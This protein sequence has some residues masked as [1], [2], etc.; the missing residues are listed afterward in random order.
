MTSTLAAALFGGLARS[1]LI[2]VDL[3]LGTISLDLPLNLKG[4]LCLLENPGSTQPKGQGGSEAG[5]STS[6]G[7]GAPQSAG[8]AVNVC[9]MKECTDGAAAI[10]VSLN[11]LVNNNLEDPDVSAAV[12]TNVSAVLGPLENWDNDS[13]YNDASEEVMLRTWVKRQMVLTVH[14]FIGWLD[15]MWS[16]NQMTANKQNLCG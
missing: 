5:G 10:L 2:S 9:A 3:S 11:K 15:R 16:R 14:H 12:R 13:N 6:T 8:N 4:L 1:A 7:A